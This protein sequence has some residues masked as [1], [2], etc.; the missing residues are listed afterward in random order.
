MPDIKTQT[1]VFSHDQQAVAAFPAAGDTAEAIVSKLAIPSYKAV[2]LVLG[3]ADALDEALKPRLTQLFGRGV[4]KAAAEASAVI[5]GGGTQA[6]I[7]DLMG[8]GVAG[9]GHKSPLIGVAP[10][11]KVTYPVADPPASDPPANPAGTPLD[12]NHSHFVLVDRS[13]TAMLFRLAGT[14]IRNTPA[15][16]DAP[17]KPAPTEAE[18]AI[19]KVPGLAILAGGGDASRSEVL[20]AVRQRIPVIVIEGSGG[21][22]DRIAAA[23]HAKEPPPADPVLAEIL[24]EGE[25]HLHHL[26]HSVKG[27]ERLI[28]RE[29]GNDNVLLQAWET[30]ADYDLNANRQQRH[31]D[32]LQL[33]IVA[34]GV[35][36]TALV[37]I[38]QVFAP[39][40][41][42]N[43]PK[44]SPEVA[45]PTNLPGV[46]ELSDSLGAAE[47]ND[48]LGAAELWA[49]GFVG[50]WVVHHLL[51][52]T[53][54]LLTVLV[55]A[56]N[57]FRQG[58]KWLLLRAGA[59]SIKREIFRY[60]T[61]AM[62]Y[63]Q[64]A[65]QQLAQRVEAITQRTMRTEVNASALV[66]Y[67]KDQG[68]PP[69]MFAAKG[70]DD[71]FSSLTPDRYVEVRLGDQLNFFQKKAV[72]LEKQLSRLYWFTFILGGLGTY[73]AAV[74]FQAWIA[75]TT[76]LVA[77]IG[78]YLGYRQTENTLTKYNQAA[79]DLLNV[80]NWWNALSAEEQAR[81]I[82]IDSLV[83]HTEQVLQSELD[84][85][86]QQMQNALAELRKGQGFP[87]EME[88]KKEP[89]EDPVPPAQ[90]G[91]NDTARPPSTQGAPATTATTL[92]NPWPGTNQDPTTGDTTGQSGTGG[93]GNQPGTGGNG[94]V[95]PGDDTGTDPVPPKV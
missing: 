33:S 18:K 52:I 79:T 48:L 5:L 82:N 34:W 19:S 80:R 77:A 14:L 65:E 46:A 1:I 29:L 16:N 87:E 3:G 73:L 4:A 21:L 28:I 71:G 17:G 63:S 22:A 61:R 72:R 74:G 59:E 6:G 15:R 83:E 9:R 69:H 42:L 56:A 50:W 37:V 84:G 44:K 62:Y 11:G 36:G 51:I 13:E 90:P 31:F 20:L 68:F 24:A 78:T 45:E 35:I 86:I 12:P 66:P 55:A 91:N 64:N 23:W 26:S 25:I 76:A 95:P 40:K 30:F 58:S 60:R 85:W 43:A 53:P 49:N 32:R 8:E 89:V 75:L 2:I 39:R 81:Q 41:E 70:G 57:R 94:T 7:M 10:L 92:L 38:Q 27:I 47:Q 88:E 93:N 54:I 67:N